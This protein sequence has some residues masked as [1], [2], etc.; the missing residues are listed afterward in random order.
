MMR[1]VRADLRAMRETRS[2]VLVCAGAVVLAAV[3]AATGTAHQLTDLLRTEILV[4]TVLV[5]I[6]GAIAGAGEFQY[7]TIAWTLLAAP[8]RRAAAAAKVVAAAVVGAVTAALVLGVTLGVGALKEGG[9]PLGT[10]AGGLVA[11]QLVLGALTAAFGLTIGVALRNMPA[12]IASVFVLAL[13]VPIVFDAKPSLADA[14]R[15]LP[16]GE[17]S[18]AALSLGSAP[19]DAGPQLE[20]A[21]AGL[22]LLGWTALLAALAFARFRA[23]V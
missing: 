6:A 13:I 2:I 18:A 5:L 16:Y 7:G 19:A 10:G 17:G 21:V 12:A 1:L 3:T 8:D 23:D 11:G 15:F 9:P 4:L 14:A 22:V 20:T